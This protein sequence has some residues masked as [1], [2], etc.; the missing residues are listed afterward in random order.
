M[1]ESEHTNLELLVAWLDAMRR[2]DLGAMERLF[3][4]EVVWRGLPDDAICRDRAEVIEMLRERLAAGVPSTWALELVAGRDAVVLGVRSAQLR[5]IGDVALSGQL[6]N[7]FRVRDGGIVA[8]ADYVTR[9]EAL[10]AAGA[11]E[12]DWS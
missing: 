5:E 1:A 10:K 9:S 11:R 6:F 2:H 4:A 7:V 12:S 3:D 8:V